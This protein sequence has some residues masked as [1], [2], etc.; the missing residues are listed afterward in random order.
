MR[1]KKIDVC[2]DIQYKKVQVKK[3]SSLMYPTGNPIAVLLVSVLVLLTT[4]FKR[5]Y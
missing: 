1:K 5:R 2:N 3:V 4:S